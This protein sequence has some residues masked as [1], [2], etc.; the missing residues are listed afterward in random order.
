MVKKYTS[1][2]LIFLKMKIVDELIKMYY[3]G[4]SKEQIIDIMFK[5]CSD[6]DERINNR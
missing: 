3:E 6:F 1:E 5:C 2:N 4:Y